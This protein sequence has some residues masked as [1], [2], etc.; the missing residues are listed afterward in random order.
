MVRVGILLKIFNS[1]GP[2]AGQVYPHPHTPQNYDD[3][4]CIYLQANIKL[5]LKYTR[6]ARTSDC[7][8]LFTIIL[9]LYYNKYIHSS[10][11]ILSNIIIINYYIM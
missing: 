5:T 7:P 6:L 3:S 9:Y 1:L 11:Y 2:K 10:I 4:V 8:T